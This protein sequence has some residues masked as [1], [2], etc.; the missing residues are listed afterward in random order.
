MAEN[1]AQIKVS[2]QERLEEKKGHYWVL[3][4]PE[5]TLLITLGGVVVAMANL[6]IISKLAPITENLAVITT[7][8]S[9]LE[10]TN[11]TFVPRN[12]FT[13][14]F[15]DIADRLNRME[16]KLDRVIETRR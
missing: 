13:A 14:K 9:A 12:E 8:V 3:A 7:R 11:G 2:T 4:R 16:T 6:W 1:M 15:D 10:E 5:V